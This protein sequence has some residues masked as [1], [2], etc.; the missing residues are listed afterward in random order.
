[1]QSIALRGAENMG[2]FWRPKADK[3]SQ[4]IELCGGPNMGIGST[5]FI[6]A[7]AS[8]GLLLA[9]PKNSRVKRF[10]PCQSSVRCG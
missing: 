8:G 4:K 9:V 6:V 3:F 1:M 10:S 7:G 5:N 2:G